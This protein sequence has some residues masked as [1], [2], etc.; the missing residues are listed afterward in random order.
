MEQS[1]F[2]RPW[3]AFGRT[4]LFFYVIH[5]YVMALLGVALRHITGVA[6]VALPLVAI[7]WLCV[8][9]PIMFVL[10]ERYAVFKARQDESSLW[11]F[12]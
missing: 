8:L 6:G 3:L 5:F 1:T 2:A 7:G 12:L 10:C 4:P 9:L 11:R